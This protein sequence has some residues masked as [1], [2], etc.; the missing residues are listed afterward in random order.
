MLCPHRTLLCLTTLLCPHRTLLCLTTLHLSQS[1][2]TVP[3]RTPHKM[4]YA[5]RVLATL[6]VGSVTSTDSF[7]AQRDAGRYQS[8]RYHRYVLPL[9]AIRQYQIPRADTKQWS[10]ASDR[11]SST[12]HNGLRITAVVAHLGDLFLPWATVGCCCVWQ[13]SLFFL[14]SLQNT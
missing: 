2:L 1:Y 13:Q 3:L 12:D 9:A 14:R 7:L 5:R 6:A 4:H 10:Q 8:V 11:P